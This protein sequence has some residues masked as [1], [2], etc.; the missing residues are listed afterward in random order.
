MDESIRRFSRAAETGCPREA[1]GE[2]PRKREG[3]ISSVVSTVQV[4]KRSPGGALSWAR[5]GGSGSNPRQR[6]I[7]R[8]TSGSVL[9]ART[10]LSLP[11]WSQRRKKKP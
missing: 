4:A 11:Q 8:T 7:A 2:G 3:E 6:R 1:D 9:T 10:R 5:R